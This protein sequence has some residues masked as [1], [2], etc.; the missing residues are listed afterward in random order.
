MSL[1]PACSALPTSPG[2]SLSINSFFFFSTIFIASFESVSSRNQ[3]A[4][5]GWNRFFSLKT[6]LQL[7]Q[8]WLKQLWV[9][10]DFCQPA[11]VFAG[12]IKLT[13]HIT[14]D[15]WLGFGDD[16]G[17]SLPPVIW[18]LLLYCLFFRLV[19]WSWFFISGCN[20][21]LFSLWMNVFTAV[22]ASKWSIN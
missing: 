5:T 20:K 16:P 17:L 21:W 2:T 7:I 3:E 12:S 19:R 14:Q 4:D 11:C 22:Q 15:H 10:Q 18:T 9:R 6:L 8:L 13:F 1:Y